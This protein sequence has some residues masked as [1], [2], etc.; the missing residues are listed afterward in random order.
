MIFFQINASIN[1]VK[2]LWNELNSFKKVNFISYRYTLGSR[3]VWSVWEVIFCLFQ[4]KR[5]H[6]CLVP[7]EV[8]SNHTYIRYLWFNPPQI[9][10]NK[11]YPKTLSVFEVL[12]VPQR[13]SEATDQTHT[14]WHWGH[15]AAIL[16]EE[17][18]NLAEWD[19]GTWAFLFA[20]S[21]LLLPTY[22]SSL[23]G[24]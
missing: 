24:L 11:C 6:C 17:D 21:S 5:V 3:I 13:W 9:G 23:P 2:R 10:W 20:F 18:T 19:L 8:L 7:R 22:L 15:G 14:A 4:N 16:G 1:S 12:G